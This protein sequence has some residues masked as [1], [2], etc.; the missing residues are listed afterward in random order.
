MNDAS[1]SPAANAAATPRAFKNKTLAALLAALLG[2]LGLHR[3]Y[4]QG[5]GAWQPWVYPAATI[6]GMLAALL[7]LPFLTLSVIVLYTG[8]IEALV[9]AL[10]ADEKWDARW[11]ADTGQTN[12]SRWGVVYIAALT[13]AFGVGLLMTLLAISF[14]A[15]LGATPG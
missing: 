3:F 12:D 5:T 10:M 8:F 6:A 14:Q 13:L 7:W 2:W 9:F 1:P 11:N 15:L 4:L